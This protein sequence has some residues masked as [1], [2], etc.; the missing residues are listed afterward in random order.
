MPIDRLPSTEQT[1]DEMY[2]KYRFIYP[3]FLPDPDP[4]HRNRL[5]EKLEHLD[6]IARRTQITIP[7]F[8]VGSI[9]AVTYSDPH[10]PGKTNRF[11]GICI[12][13]KGCGLRANFLLRN[14]IDNLGV[15]IKYDMYDP[16]IRMIECLRLEKRLDDE[17]IYLRDAP[18]EYSTFPLDMEAEF[19]PESAEIPVNELKVPL[20]PRPWSAKWEQL[21]MKGLLPFE[22]TDKRRKRAEKNAKPWLK[23]D[24]M[25]KYRETIPMEEQQEIFSEVYNKLMSLEV[26]R[27]Q[28]KLKRTFVRPKKTG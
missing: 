23:Y 27:Q 20:N 3:E 7:H 12:Q 17:L 22:V 14:I 19:L 10:A 26:T 21:D 6:M 4:K 24:L 18:P 11:V 16:S 5:R 9:L 28:M 8:Y 2:L 1:I 13:R 25:H 15:E